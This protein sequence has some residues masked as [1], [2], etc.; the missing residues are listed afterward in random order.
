MA[1]SMLNLMI[2]TFYDIVG[3]QIEET[4]NQMI[5]FFHIQPYVLSDLSFERQNFIIVIDGRS[6]HPP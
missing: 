4:G 3:F 1:P 6:D 2:C 5:T